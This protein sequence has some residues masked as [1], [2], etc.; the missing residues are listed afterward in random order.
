VDFTVK[1]CNRYLFLVGDNYLETVVPKM[2]GSVELRSG[3][4]RTCIC[5]VDA[6]RAHTDAPQPLTAPSSIFWPIGRSLTLVE[7]LQALTVAPQALIHPQVLLLHYF[8]QSD[9]RERL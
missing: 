5:P 3:V 9:A 8:G 2:P 1:L 6:P 7:A 4:V